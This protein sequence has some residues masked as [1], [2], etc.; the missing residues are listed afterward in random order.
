MPSSNDRSGG[1]ESRRQTGAIFEK[2]AAQFFES[3]GYEVLEKNWQAGHR[4]IDLIARKGA[5][6]VFVEVKSSIDKS[7]GHPAER[8]DKTKIKRLSSAAQQYLLTK[9]IQGV[10]LRFDVVTFTGGNLEH[11]PSAF[12]FEE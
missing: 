7:F 3:Q 2:L 1:R 6:I 9:N 5:M 8:V 12:E 4:E 10:D 11:Y